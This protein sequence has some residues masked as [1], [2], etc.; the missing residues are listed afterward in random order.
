MLFL[1]VISSFYL[2]YMPGHFMGYFFDT[3]VV[4]LIGYAISAPLYHLYV[5]LVQRKP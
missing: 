4:L 1:L 3:A 2:E 5:P